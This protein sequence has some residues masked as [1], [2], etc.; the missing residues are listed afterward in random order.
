MENEELKTLIKQCLNELAAEKAGNNS[1][2]AF[3]SLSAEEQDRVR[4]EIINEFLKN[5]FDNVNGWDEEKIK[6]ANNGCHSSSYYRKLINKL[7]LNF[8]VKEKLQ[9]LKDFTIK[10][11]K[12]VLE[13]GK[14]I[15]ESLKKLAAQ[16]P[17]TVSGII[18]GL[19]LGLLISCIPVIGHAISPV[20]IPILVLLGVAEGFLADMQQ[21]S[22]F[23]KVKATVAG[24]N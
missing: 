24:T 4:E 18:V 9:T 20:V 5:G 13:I 6:A 16:L 22:F 14:L 1:N 17:N 7:D 8:K 21:V 2:M 11:G 10:I 15:L 19:F 23:A 12:T 3:S